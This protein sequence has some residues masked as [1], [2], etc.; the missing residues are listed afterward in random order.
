MILKICNLQELC[1]NISG[2]DIWNI[3]LKSFS[4]LK[5]LFLKVT[6][7]KYLK[8]DHYRDKLELILKKSLSSLEYLHIECDTISKLIQ[9]MAEIKDSIKIIKKDAI[10]IKLSGPHD[11]RF[12]KKKLLEDLLWNLSKSCDDFTLHL[13]SFKIRWRLRDI[14]QHH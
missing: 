6:A 14:Y 13:N 2:D 9:T 5:R 10:I 3:T 8:D 1:L 7:C 11:V 4:N 12:T